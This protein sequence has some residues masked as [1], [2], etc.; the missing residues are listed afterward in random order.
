M[1][2]GAIISIIGLSFTLLSSG[3]TAA[4]ICVIKFNDFS[5][6]QKDMEGMKKTQ[7]IICSNIKTIS[8][9]VANIE[10]RLEIRS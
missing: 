8:E 7:Q 4:M 10:G 6:Q 3:F 2:V 1:E 5:H 9:R